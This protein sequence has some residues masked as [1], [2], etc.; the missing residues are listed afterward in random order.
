LRS[1]L[2][3]RIPQNP[4]DVIIYPRLSNDIDDVV[5][6]SLSLSLSLEKAYKIDALLFKR[7]LLRRV[8]QK[9]CWFMAI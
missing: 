4:T 6:S 5:A 8:L 3:D 2:C 7:K 9:W 1:R